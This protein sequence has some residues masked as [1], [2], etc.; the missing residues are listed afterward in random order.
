MTTSTEL[1]ALDAEDA[2]NL[3]MAHELMENPGL[4]GRLSNMIGEPIEAG[5]EKLPQNVQKLIGEAV[6]KAI[7]AAFQVAL[8]TMNA[9]PSEVKAEPRKSGWW[10]KAVS[11]AN[12][13]VGGVFGTGRDAANVDCVPPKASNLLLR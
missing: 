2:K 11:T 3:K 12:D 13:A 1:V 4:V 7:N 5:M 6:E 10:Q 8:K 9:V